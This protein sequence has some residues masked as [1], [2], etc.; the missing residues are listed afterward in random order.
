MHLN[1]PSDA[2]SWSAQCAYTF[3]TYLEKDKKYIIQFYAKSSS[4]SGSLQFQ[5]QNGTTYGSQGG[6]N[7]FAIGTDWNMT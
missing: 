4:A 2:D 1:N 7:T 3:D 6:Y 5:Y